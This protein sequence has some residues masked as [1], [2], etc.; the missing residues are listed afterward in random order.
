MYNLHN[1]LFPASIRRISRDL[2]NWVGNND[3]KVLNW[4]FNKAPLWKF[5]VFQAEKQGGKLLP[6]FAF[7]VAMT[8]HR[9]YLTTAAYF[10]L[11]VFLHAAYI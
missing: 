5:R 9:V 10:C 1:F 6:M 4:K 2:I 7:L 11:A 3:A 8:T